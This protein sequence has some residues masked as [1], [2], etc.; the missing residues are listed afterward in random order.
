ME[1][2]F[3]TTCRLDYD[4]FEQS[5]K[6]QHQKLKHSGLLTV[7][8]HQTLAAEI[9]KALTWEELEGVSLQISQLLCDANDAK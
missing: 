3:V 1:E 6:L 8:E 7:A 5:K 9:D 2:L 4:Q